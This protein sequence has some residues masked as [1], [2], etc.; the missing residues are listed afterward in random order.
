[1]DI[2]TMI[3]SYNIALTDAASEILGKEHHRKRHWITKDVLDLS[4]E[5]EI[6]EEAV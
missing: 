5:G 6:E 4:V 3:T 1:M 2:D